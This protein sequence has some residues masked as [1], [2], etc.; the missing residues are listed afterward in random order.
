[1]ILIAVQTITLVVVAFDRNA[2][3]T[4]GTNG[5]GNNEGIEGLRPVNSCLKP[6]GL[7]GNVRNRHLPFGIGSDAFFL[8]TAS[9]SRLTI[10]RSISDGLPYCLR[11]SFCVF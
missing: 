10:R 4:K 9:I 6:P 3:G 11:Q 1:M 8:G 7:L 5:G 2:K